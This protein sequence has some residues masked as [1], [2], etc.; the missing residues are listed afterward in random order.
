MIHLQ[1]KEHQRLLANHWKL[2]RG[3]K[4]EGGK[5][6]FPYSFHREHVPAAELILD[7]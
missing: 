4:L 1:A 2:G 7:F 6:G 3:K 5:E